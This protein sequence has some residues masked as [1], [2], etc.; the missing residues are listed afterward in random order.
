MALGVNG[1]RQFASKSW[2]RGSY[3]LSTADT[4]SQSTTDEQLLQGQAVSANRAETATGQSDNLSHKLNLNAQHQ[5]N[6]W[7]QLRFRGNFSAGSNTSNDVSLQETLRPD[8][9]FQNSAVSRVATESDNLSGDGRLTYSKR[10]NQAGRS[11]IAEAWGDLSTPDQF[12]NLSSSTDFSN[13]QGGVTT[14]DILQSQRRDS[15]TLTTG[16]RL[17]LTE[18]LGGGTVLEIFGQHRAISE[19]QN[20]DVNDL[21]TGTPIPNTDLSRAFER[22]YSYLQGG[23]RFSRNTAGLRWVVGLEVQ[24]SDLQGT[25]IGRDESID[26]GFTNVLPSANLRY[27]FNQGSN[28]T[29]NYRTS[30]RDPSLNELQPFV[31]NTDPLRIYAGNPDLT[32]QY[33]HS[34]RTDF[35]RFDQFTFRSVYLYANVGYNRNQIVQSRVVDAQGRQTVMPVNLGDGWNGNIGGSYGTPIRTLGAQVDLE[36]SYTRSIGQELVNAVENE[37]RTANHNI[38]LR[39]QNRSKEI[40]DLNAG[41]RWGFNSVRYSINSALDQSYLNSTYYGEG[42]WFVSEAWSVNASANYQVFDQNLFGP[43]DNIFLLGASVG[44]QLFD[45]RGEVRIYGVDLLNENNGI[46]ITSTSSYIRQRQA[47]TLGRRVMVQFSYQLGSNL[48]PP[49]E[50]RGGGRRGG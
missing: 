10:F 40:F 9:S 13:G 21:V 33:Q 20:Y 31:D 17:A 2:L 22:T 18:P 37:S 23:S 6:A 7:N 30:T 15:R 42:T 35:R 46:S 34:L 28:I 48:A 12:S 38:G 4:R 8:G 29:I 5:F 1:S 27:Q 32:P 44:R 19:D 39:L 45:N 3:F 41:A 16:Q 43:R 49:R 50:G 14:R 26:N 36:Y 25:I 11:V 24:A 47:P